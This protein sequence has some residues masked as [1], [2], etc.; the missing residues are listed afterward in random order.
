MLIH[1]TSL[2]EM[3]SIC[4]ELATHMQKFEAEQSAGIWTITLLS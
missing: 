2:N 4:V 1:T 3:I